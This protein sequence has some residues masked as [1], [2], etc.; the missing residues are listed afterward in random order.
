MAPRAV[1]AGCRAACCSH[2]ERAFSAEKGA[3][4]KGRAETQ[5]QT[6][7]KSAVCPT[8]W[9]WCLSDVGLRAVRGYAGSCLFLSGRFCSADPPVPTRSPG[10]GCGT[11]EEQETV[12]R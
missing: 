7:K 8:S 4:R 12:T 3:G 11:E 9:C 5:R 1:S 10:G 2:E 6:I